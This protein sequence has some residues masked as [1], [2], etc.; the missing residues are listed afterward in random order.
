LHPASGADSFQCAADMNRKEI[1]ERVRIEAN[2]L[3]ALVKKLQYS[4]EHLNWL[5]D[6][7]ESEGKPSAAP[8]QKPAPEGKFRKLINKV[9]GE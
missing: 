5:A 1:A 4:S 9:Y 3:A 8:N 2:E 6:A 7:L